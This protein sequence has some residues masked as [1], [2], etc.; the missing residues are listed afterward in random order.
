M[1]PAPVSTPEDVKNQILCAAGARF[2]LHGFH[3]TTMAE[4][5]QDC[6][7]SAA[8]LYRY[9]ES[10]SDI[11]AAIAARHFATKEQA[12]RE[13][14]R[15]PGLSASQ[16][17]EVFIIENMR[18]VYDEFCNQPRVSELVE[19]IAAEHWDLVQRHLDTNRALLAEVLA[20]G[21]R[22]GEFD[23]PDV[24]ASA[25]AIQMATAKFCTPLM[26]LGKHSL[27]ELERL[28]RGVVGLLIRGLR[29]Q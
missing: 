20:E 23:V 6:K 15:R 1:K 25:E 3:K 28:A 5:A 14:V 27:D 29:K 24:V 4:I 2:A 8:N 18:C 21:N 19:F 9:F 10:K 13:V 7:M 12:W 22:T 16:R 11:G 17:L 26:M